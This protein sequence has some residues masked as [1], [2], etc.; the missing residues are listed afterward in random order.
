MIF[1]FKF[2][3]FELTARNNF[4]TISVLKNPLKAGKYR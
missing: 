1:R 4:S 2:T 3:F